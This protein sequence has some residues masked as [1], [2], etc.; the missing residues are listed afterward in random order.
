MKTDYD[1]IIIGGGPA[2]LTAAIYTSRARLN[3]LILEKE[4]M[5]G[6]L[7]NRELIENYPCLAE[8]VQGPDLAAGMASQAMN[9]GAKFEYAEVSDIETTEDCKVVHCDSG[10][11]TCKGI[12]IASGSQP[13][14]LGVPGEDE[15]EYRGVF[16]C[17]TCDGPMYEG[18]AVAVAGGGDSAVTEA[19]ALARYA[20]KV[21]LIARSSL[22]ASKVLQ[23]RIAADPKIDVML[24][25]RITEITGGEEMTGLELLNGDTGATSHLDADGL[26]VRIGQLPNTQFLKGVLELTAG[27]Q[28]PVNEN[29]E[30]SI[31]GIF[32][33]GDVREHSPMQ[34]STAVGD[35]A[36]AAM[37]LGRYLNS[38]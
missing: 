20:S 34:I 29:M 1:V 16:Y 24:A 11:Y 8:G 15:F 17:G 28:I 4:S 27:G 33:A 32:A 5:G 6:E 25:T 26:C 13:R 14:R 31:Q 37:A 7:S 38:H 12:I 30:T 36:C 35:G 10:D 22:R 2:G 23:E 18:K 9:F 19:L 21:T 3:T